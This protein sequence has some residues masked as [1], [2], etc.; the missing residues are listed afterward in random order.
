MT[1]NS[2]PFQMAAVSAA[3]RWGLGP[4]SGPHEAQR[5]FLRRVGSAKFTYDDRLI[6]ELRLLTDDVAMTRIGR[7]LADQAQGTALRAFAASQSPDPKVF[8]DAAR[9]LVAETESAL[10][11]RWYEDWLGLVSVDG[12]PQAGTYFECQKPPRQRR[13]AITAVACIEAP[14]DWPVTPAARER[15]EESRIELDEANLV[16]ALSRF[17]PKAILG[18]LALLALGVLIDYKMRR[19]SDS[20]RQLLEIRERIERR[21]VERSQ[22]SS[23][24]RPQV[25]PP[26]NE[27]PTK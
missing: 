5:E 11:R 19:D 4:Q 27:T 9:R 17:I 10:S 18:V 14:E 6:A 2:A 16:K 15:D 1:S 13:P 8:Q 7:R 20:R 25:S 24:V 12:K 22:W 23:G 26:K 3:A 21:R